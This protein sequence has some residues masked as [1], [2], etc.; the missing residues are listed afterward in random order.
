MR[1]FVFFK[2]PDSINKA[3]Q[4]VRSRPYFYWKK[5][6]EEM[7]LN[8]F[9]WTV[10]KVIGYRVF[11]RQHKIDPGKIRT[12]EDFKTLP[13]TS[14]N[15]YLRETQYPDLFPDR[16]LTSATTVSA[17]SGS[18]GEPFYFPRCG[19]HDDLYQYQAEIFLKEQFEID[20]KKTLGVLGFGLGIWIGGIFTY[21]VMERI[22]N[23]GYRF[24]I[25]PTGTNKEEFFKVIKKFGRIYDQILLMGYP[26]FI[27]DILDEG[28]DHGIYWKD[29]EIKI[30]TAAEGFSEKFREYI[31]KKAGLKNM[32]SDIVNL[33]GTVEFGTMAHETA[34]TNLIRHLASKDKKLFKT[35]FPEATNIPTLAQYHS[36]LFYFE[37]VKIENKKEVIGTGYGAGIPLIRYRFHDLGGVIPYEMMMEKLS[38]CGLNLKNEMKKYHIS[39]R[40]TY[41]LPFVYVYARSDF[42][43][44]FRGANIYPEE[45]RHALDGHKLSK[46][47]TGRFTMT[48]K[49]DKKLNQIFEINAELRKKVRSNKKLTEIIKDNIVNHLCENN[50]EYRDVYQSDSVQ[51]LPTIVFW[52]YRH[53]LYFSHVGKQLWVK[54]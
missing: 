52:T 21:K 38:V 7:A 35:L 16:N 22:S 26:P 10:N 1:N 29:Y 47:I 18:T 44:V 27:K 2:P 33:Y 45:I 30:L 12:I 23:K 6:G 43:V 36:D 9:H 24:T 32:L 11:L 14:K 31:A 46:F 48:R 5:K 41:K 25:V 34:V 4:D 54:K 42:S 40:L 28:K 37:E 19:F 39:P 3:I 53:P 8:L 17:T 20:K 50:S 13:L 49:E 15:K 51:A